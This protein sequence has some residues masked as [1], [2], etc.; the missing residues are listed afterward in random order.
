VLAALKLYVA[1]KRWLTPAFTAQLRVDASDRAYP[2]TPWE[3]AAK[4]WLSAR[5][6]RSLP[7]RTS[8]TVSARAGWKRYDQAA[9]D[10]SGVVTGEAPRAALWDVS[11]LVAQSLSARLAARAWWTQ[12]R[13]TES[14]DAA[15]QLAGFEN[16]LLDEFS[17]DGYRAG[18]AL[19]A[20]LPWNCTAELAGERAR[21]DYPGRPPTLYDPILN[22]FL[23]D[24]GDQVLLGPGER[25]DTLTRV[26][27]YADKRI[28]TG[29][30][31]VTV[32]LNAEWTKQDSN[33][34]YWAWDGWLIGGGAVLEF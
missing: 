23:F 7:T 9:P 2:D 20:I 13:L 6:N 18:G 10:T 11:L 31:R 5:L 22:T 4:V 34:L 21:L 30:A 27:L 29:G 28:V 19:K 8:L 24:A 26:R 3:D 17:A 12:G 32:R 1:L 33:D 25:R 14:A 15:R 16:P